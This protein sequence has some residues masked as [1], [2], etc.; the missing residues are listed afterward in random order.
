MCILEG[1]SLKATL[2][3]FLPIQSRLMQNLAY[4]KENFADKSKFKT[5][6]YQGEEEVLNSFH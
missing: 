2:H 1:K 4:F 3:C 6:D 5:L